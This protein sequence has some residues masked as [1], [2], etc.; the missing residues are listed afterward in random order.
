MTQNPYTSP[1]ASVDTDNKPT[2]GPVFRP[3]AIYFVAAWCFIGLGGF[4][5]LM[6]KGFAPQL[7]ISPQAAALVVLVFSVAFV[8]G[9]FKLVRVWLIAA[10][11][12]FAMLGLFQAVTLVTSL[13]AGHSS[14]P[15]IG[16]KLFYAVPSLICAWYVSRPSFLK[17]PTEFNS[18]RKQQAMQKHVQ[19]QLLKRNA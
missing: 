10:A 4:L 7:N 6:L 13:L 8:I 2:V 18:Y 3:R 9:V 5:N 15:L 14:G 17:R 1:E 12:L 16:I 19:K 11:I